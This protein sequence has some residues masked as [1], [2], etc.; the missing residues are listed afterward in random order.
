MEEEVTKI[1]NSEGLVIDG[2]LNAHIGSDRT[3]L[4]D[5][6]GQHGFGVVNREGEAILEFVKNKTLRILNTYFKKDRIKIVTYASGDTETQPDFVLM[7]PKSDMMAVD[8]RF[9]R[10]I[11]IAHRT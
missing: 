7:G 11:S 3:G 2:D 4:E 9:K 1:P 10:F 8:C 5:V 6:R